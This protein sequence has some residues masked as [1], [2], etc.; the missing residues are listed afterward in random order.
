MSMHVPVLDVGRLRLLREVA[1][2]GTIAAAARTLGLTASAVSQQLSL[3]EREA[4]T[5][6]L[7]R[8]SRGVSLTGAGRMLADRAGEVLDVLSQARADLD[9][10]SGSV[11]GQVRLSSVASAAAALV[12]P[13]VLALRTTQPG[14]AVSVLAAEPAR[15]LDLL[16]AG[17]VDIAVVDEY[18]YVPMALPEALAAHELRTE[19]LVIVSARGD[20]ATARL[21]D[22]A[23]RDWV[24]PPDDAACG[25]AVRSACRAAGFEPRVVWE[26]DDMLLLARAVG[27]GHGVAVLPPLAV[28]AAA[29]IVT[30]PLREP[31]LRRRLVAL[32]RASVQA[33]PVVATVLAQLRAVAR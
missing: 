18:D 24:M 12:S 9:Q 26:T 23:D 28:A 16:L 30:S 32:A 29:D 15:S 25:L 33:R 22:L 20:Q 8:S 27:A 4:G 6:L 5:P 2:R 14:I 7:D 21:R 1:L 3:L 11:T 31:V 19:E 13:A 10:L 17:D